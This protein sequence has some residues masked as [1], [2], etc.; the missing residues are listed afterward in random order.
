MLEDFP[1]TKTLVGQKADYKILE[2]IGEGGKGKTYLA[3]VVNSRDSLAIGYKCV[4]KIP[5]IEFPK[6]TIQ[7]NIDWLQKIQ[8]S[9]ANEL[10]SFYRLQGLDCAAEILDYGAIELDIG[11]KKHPAHF[12]VQRHIKG[13]QLDEI[14]PKNLGGIKTAKE[15]FEWCRKLTEALLKIHQREVIHADIWPAN[16]MVYKGEIVF[17]DF[18][19]GILKDIDFITE[20]GDR[21]GDHYNYVAPERRN[22]KMRWYVEADI[23]SLGGIFYYLATGQPPPI[24]TEDHDKL[25]EKITRNIKRINIELYNANSGVVDVIA[26]C[27]RYKNLHRTP[28]AEGILQDL[29]IFTTKN[30]RNRDKKQ[31][32]ITKNI[33]K[34]LDTLKKH[35]NGLFCWMAY[36]E[37]SLFQQKLENMQQGVYD[38]TGDYDDIINGLCRNLAILSQGHKYI[39]VST[40][41]FWHPDNLGV[42]GRFLTMNKLVAQRGACIQRIF[43][44]TDEDEEK[45]EYLPHILR[46]H[47]GKITE[48]RKEGF[49]NDD[50]NKAG[51]HEWVYKATIEER[52]LLFRRGG[53]FGLWKK[54]GQSMLISPVYNE[55]RRIVIIRFRSNSPYNTEMSKIFKGLRQGAKSLI[56][57]RIKSK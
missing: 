4:V 13:E 6:F 30:V 31:I 55:N 19:Q 17:I 2:S 27:L 21:R 8:N 47:R 41:Q 39:T 44:V 1:K 33:P 45:D 40:P 25:K 49:Q 57:Y 35:N 52:E 46:A 48:L 51:L 34:E 50:I 12:L 24:P 14:F 54:R 11:D 38:L 9:F 16:I 42:N 5:K 37:I 36:S 10:N 28:H 56:N 32:E 23:Y 18:G 7:Q 22:L 43:L 26:R 15:Y 3:E 53:H 20:I 29:D